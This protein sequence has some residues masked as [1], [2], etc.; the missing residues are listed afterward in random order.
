MVETPVYL[1]QLARGRRRYIWHNQL[2]AVAP[3][4]DHP[5]NQV[6]HRVIDHFRF[7][8]MAGCI[9]HPVITGG[10]DTRM[11]WAAPRVAVEV[12][13]QCQDYTRDKN[14]CQAAYASLTL[15]LKPT[16]GINPG[17]R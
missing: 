1:A 9:E 17:L 16:Y 10:L 12:V 11:E 6:I 13:S 2:V 7:T 8:E 5:G 3:R 15:C 4:A 14:R